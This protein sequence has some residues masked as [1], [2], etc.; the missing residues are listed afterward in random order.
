MLQSH[1]TPLSS[2]IPKSYFP[3]HVTSKSD[4]RLAI[5]LQTFLFD[6][7]FSFVLFD[8]GVCFYLDLLVGLESK[9]TTPTLSTSAIFDYFELL[10]LQSNTHSSRPTSSNANSKSPTPT[11]SCVNLDLLV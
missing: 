8:L 5:W 6:A 2:S 10:V 4:D 9:P 3:N 11:F 7:Y 1:S